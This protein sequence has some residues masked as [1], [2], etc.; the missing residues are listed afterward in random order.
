MPI[1][2]TAY[3]TSAQNLITYPFDDS[4][5]IY[6]AQL[7]G[8]GY[9]FNDSNTTRSDVGYFVGSPIVITGKSIT[10]E[11]TISYFDCND[12]DFT[13]QGTLDAAYIIVHLMNGGSP[14]PTDKL[15]L[16][17]DINA[18]QLESIAIPVPLA[19]DGLMSVAGV[20]GYPDPDVTP[21]PDPDPEPTPD[22]DGDP[23]FTEDFESYTVGEPWLLETQT[24][25]VQG[26]DH[27]GNSS[28]MI[29]CEY[30]PLS[31]GSFR[32]YRS[33]DL[34]V[35]LNH[36]KL[37]FRVY[38]EEGFDFSRGGKMHGFEPEDEVSGGGV[39]NPDEYSAR[40]MWRDNGTVQCYDYHQDMIYS[41]GEGVVSSESAFQVG[42]WHHVEMET[43]LNTGELTTDGFN[44]MSVDGVAYS[45]NL[46]RR[47]R[48]VINDATKINAFVFVTF[49]GGNSIDWAPDQTVYA[50]FND[51][52]VYDLE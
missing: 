44:I 40:M 37:S 19:A 32:I 50:L 38:F 27:N 11:G 12:F 36:A 9:T 18:G 5:I 23:V 8:D 13:S 6:A 20:Q 31:I 2:S 26:V 15:I 51:F 14:R 4:S 21:D 52:K 10:R 45:T 3:A 35:L 16:C 41:Y 28:Q 46:N 33:V 7:V 25:I 42:K 47:F 1:T 48:A 29:R 39:V 49:F 22:P 34:P 43:K 17:I 24:E 30:I